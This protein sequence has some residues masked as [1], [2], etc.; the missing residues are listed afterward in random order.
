MQ[1]LERY[2]Q[3]AN[4]NGFESFLHKSEDCAS[5]LF[6]TKIDGVIFNANV[7]VCL[8]DNMRM[9]KYNSKT[10]EDIWSFATEEE[11][12]EA[13][14]KYRTWGFATFNYPQPIE[15]E[16]DHPQPIENENDHFQPIENEND[17]P[18]QP[19]ENENDHHQPI[20]NMLEKMQINETQNAKRCL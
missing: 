19:I 5:Y 10:K 17:P 7:S 2:I 20:E 6:E 13:L 16:N 3:L 18:S 8:G 9:H 14:N 15:N 1:T 11:F 12:V 4:S